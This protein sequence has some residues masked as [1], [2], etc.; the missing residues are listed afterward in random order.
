MSTST[1]EPI[2]AKVS[3]DLKRRIRL[4]AALSNQNMSELVREALEE[5]F[6][7]DPQVEKMLQSLD[8]EELE[9]LVNGS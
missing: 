3:P 8:E 6:G 9:E 7:N 5:Q 1:T 4:K 2:G